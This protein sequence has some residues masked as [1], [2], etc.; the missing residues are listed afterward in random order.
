[1]KLFPEF[2]KSK[3]DTKDLKIISNALV[4]IKSSYPVYNEIHQF[5]KLEDN[6]RNIENLEQKFVDLSNIHNSVTSL[7]EQ[8]NNILLRKHLN[9]QQKNTDQLIQ[10]YCQ[11]TA[12]A[13][14]FSNALQY[15]DK[16]NQKHWEKYW[17]IKYWKR[18]RSKQLCYFVVS[19]YLYY[20][21]KE[22]G[23][24]CLLEEKYLESKKWLNKI[25]GDWTEYKDHKLDQI[26]KKYKS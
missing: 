25:K 7:F 6:K 8:K 11:Q 3:E 5:K 9:L 13:Q 19:C 4:P 22:G 14:K 20:W 15:K 18:R 1:M 10:Q 17:K 2:F 12:V 21:L 23:Y 24:I 26:K 16:K